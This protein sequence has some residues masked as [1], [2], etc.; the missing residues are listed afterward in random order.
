MKY[1]IVAAG[2]GSRL[3]AGGITT[4]KPLTLL[5]GV[6]M[7]KRIIDVLMENDAESITVATNAA[8]PEIADYL[9]SL[10]KNIPLIVKEIVSPNNYYSL[11]KATEDIEGKYIGLTVDT[12]FEPKAFSEYVETYV[13]YAETEALM[14]VTGYIDDE[15][16]L[17]VKINDE[18]QVEDYGLVPFEGTQWVSAGIYGLSSAIMSE[19]AKDSSID[20]LNSFQKWLTKKGVNVKGYDLGKAFDVDRPQEIGDAEE[21]IRAYS[22]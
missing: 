13:K 5:L 9:R 22:K 3:Q 6:P 15:K 12:I 10:D 8:I 4:P 20:C 17:Y 19:A 2:A 16:P 7:I 18:M 14:G 11:Q 21:F 1:A